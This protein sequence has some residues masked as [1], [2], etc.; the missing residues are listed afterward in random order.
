MHHN[1][2][3]ALQD[4]LARAIEAEIAPLVAELKR[5]MMVAIRKEMAGCLIYVPKST[6]EERERR[7][8][9]L[10]AEYHN[11]ASV[12]KLAKKYGI[13]AR[14]VYTIVQRGR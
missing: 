1:D 3:D 13:R 10:I 8:T 12:R 4:C 6:A 5:A 11:G 7:N 2:L 9:A 14:Q